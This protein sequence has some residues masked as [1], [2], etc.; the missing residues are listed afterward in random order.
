MRATLIVT[1][2]IGLVATTILTVFIV[3][4]SRAWGGHIGL[5]LAIVGG[6]IGFVLASLSSTIGYNHDWYRSASL[7]GVIMLSA[8]AVPWLQ[9]RDKLAGVGMVLVALLWVVDAWKNH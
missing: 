6:F 8:S 2:I 9:S 5:P 1:S 3:S 7:L 4:W